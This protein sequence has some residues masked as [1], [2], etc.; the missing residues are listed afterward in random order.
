MARARR[1]QT[2]S[3]QLARGPLDL[4]F[5]L[6]SLLLTIVGLVMLLS[7]SAPSAYYDD[8]SPLYYFL[9]QGFFAG[10]GIVMM[11]IISRIN[12]QTFRWISIFLLGASLILLV[13]VL[14]PGIGQVRNGAQRWIMLGPIQFQPSEIA[15]VGVIM[16]FSSR[17]SKRDGYVFKPKNGDKFWVPIYNFLGRIGFLELL[18][19]GLILLAIVALLIFEPH[20]SAIILVLFIGASILFASGVEMRW[21]VLVGALAV[22]ALIVMIM[23]NPYMIERIT[24]AS[25]PWEDTRDTGYQLTQSLM[26]IGSGGLTGVGLGKSRQKY[27]FLPERHN[28]FIFAIVCEELGLVGASVIIILFVLL[29]VRGYWIALRSRDRFGSLLTVGV[30]SKLAMQVFCNIGVVTG[31]LPTTG[32]SLP[33]FS[34][35]GTALIMQLAEM[36]IVLSVSRQIPPRRGSEKKEKKGKVEAV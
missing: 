5:L 17:L 19:Y 1:D 15:K 29:I 7:A 33:F 2:L 12:Y 32:I 6:L 16:Y 10:V 3:E 8:K 13:L 25:D 14:I 34:Y 20:M 4:P 24:S 31:F 36:G 30:V 28:D 18:P 27:M 11:F 9:R 22:A 35:G 21:F 23:A 26:A